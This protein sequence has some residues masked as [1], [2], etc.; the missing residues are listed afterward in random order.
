MTV[1]SREETR[2]NREGT[3]KAGK[4][5]LKHHEENREGPGQ[6]KREAQRAS[7]AMRKH[8]RAVRK[9]GRSWGKQGK[10]EAAGGRRGRQA[11]ENRKGTSRIGEGPGRKTSKAGKGPL[12]HHEENREGP[13]QKKREA[14]RASRA[15]RKHGRAVRKQGR[16][17]GKQGKTEAA[18]G[19]R[20]RQAGENRKGTSRIGEGPGRKGDGPWK[21]RGGAGKKQG[22]TGK[23]AARTGK[24]LGT[25]DWENRRREE[26]GR[27][28]ATKTEP[29][30]IREGMGDKRGRS[31]EKTGEEPARIGKGQER[32]WKGR[33]RTREVSYIMQRTCSIQFGS[34]Y[35]QQCIYYFMLSV[36]VLDQV[37]SNLSTFSNVFNSFLFIFFTLVPGVHFCAFW[38][39]HG[40]KRGS[41]E[42]SGSSFWTAKVDKTCPR[43]WM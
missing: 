21:Y 34:T 42:A 3:S 14:Q 6:K 17:W 4:G 38:V 13:G 1:K 26:S 39:P 37:W 31:M 40:C 22:R 27:E 7:R 41:K 8:G 2:A 15:M 11:G 9:Q 10:T 33:G 43:P 24:D 25:T 20:G 18:G 19:R 28:L 12:K 32:T 16:S 35:M 36:S 30:K 5:P 29:E 23:E